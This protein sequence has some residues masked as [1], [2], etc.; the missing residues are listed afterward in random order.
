[1]RRPS[2]IHASLVVLTS[3]LPWK[4]LSEQ[5]HQNNDGN[6]GE[7]PATYHTSSRLIPPSDSIKGYPLGTAGVPKGELDGLGSPWNADKEFRRPFDA[8]TIGDSNQVPSRFGNNPN[9]QHDIPPLRT[10][11]VYRY[12]ARQKARNAK[13]GSV[14][15]LL[16]GPNVDHW[17]VTA[18][19][20]SARGFNVIA[21]ASSSAANRPDGPALVLQLL[22]ALRWNKAVLVGCDSETV[23]AIQ[24]ALQLAPE[25]IVG[26]I[27]SG[28]LSECESLLVT[29]SAA[30]TTKF[31]L[32]QYLHNRLACP[33]SIIW[34]GDAASVEKN[35][36]ESSSSSSSSSSS[37]AES[38]SRVRH[39]T[40]IIGGGSAPHRRRPEIFAW[41]L[42]RFVEDK[43]APPVQIRAA[44]QRPRATQ[45]AHR[46]R[47]S[48]ASRHH[49][50]PPWRDDDAHLPWHFDEMFNE[51]SFV[52]F[53][54]VAATALFYAMALKVLFYQ[55]DSVRGGVDFM[56]T[57][58]RNTVVVIKKSVL[59]FLSVFLIF[60][61]RPRNLSGKT[62][63]KEM[64]EDRR[65]LEASEAKEEEEEKVETNDH[66]KEDDDAEVQIDDESKKNGTSSSDDKPEVETE[67]RKSPI[68]FL[69]HV[70]A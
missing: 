55:Y 19:Q 41:V 37:N 44:V 32:D 45:Q 35:A 47:D 6:T 22:D 48:A 10:P 50:F 31:A 11:I 21:V 13:A 59:K 53:G 36:D 65:Q 8:P 46:M 39:R 27:L 38:S 33:F 29:S 3:L 58:K 16:L 34:D 40:V 69:D 23:S 15:F 56:A 14:P 26:L 60:R 1:M 49:L 66:P 9:M 20:L 57:F 61:R 64:D 18:Q 25:R 30:T 52:V 68:F 70:V 4:V 63:A 42:T 54:R 7:K 28:N 67:K 12:Y 2:L 43:I 17:K 62:V 51:E 5:R 24:A